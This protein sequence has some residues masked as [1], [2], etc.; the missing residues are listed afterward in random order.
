MFCHACF[1][2]IF[3]LSQTDDRILAWCSL[4]RII[5]FV[6][7][8]YTPEDIFMRNKSK[9]NKKT[10]Y[11]EEMRLIVPEQGIMKSAIFY[12]I[13]L[14]LGTASTFG[15]FY[16]SFDIPIEFFSVISLAIIFCIVFTAMFLMKRKNTWFVLVSLILLIL[17]IIVFKDTIYR[18]LLI[19]VKYILE[20][21]RSHGSAVGF[22][23][24][25]ES[26]IKGA[27][28]KFDATMFLICTIYIFTLLEAWL[29]EKRR[30][31]ILTAFVTLPFVLAPIF[32][33]ITPSFVAI[34]GMIIFYGMLVFLSPMLSGSK[35]FRKGMKGYHISSTAS[36]NPISFLIIPIFLVAAMITSII[37]PQSGFQRSKF[38]DAIRMSIVNGFDQS[39]FSRYMNAAFGGDMDKVNL[40][41]AGNISF[42]GSRILSVTMNEN[43]TNKPHT[44]YLKGYVG[45]V[46]AEDGW[47]DLSEEQSAKVMGI[48]GQNK[49]QKIFSDIRQS[50]YSENES[51]ENFNLTVQCVA[52]DPR[53]VYIPYG[54]ANI[55]PED[56]IS[57]INDSY[58]KAVD[59]T[60]GIIEYN[61]S[62]F[63]VTDDYE[64]I[65][66]NKRLTDYVLHI[67]NDQQMKVLILD[68]G[69]AI[70]GLGYFGV[71]DN[72]YI[73]YVAEDG[74][75]FGNLEKYNPEKYYG[76]IFYGTGVENQDKTFEDIMSHYGDAMGNYTYEYF[77]MLKR[78][79]DFA[80]ENYTQ[81]PESLKAS[82][83]KFIKENKIN[84]NST[85]ETVRDIKSLFQY[86]GKYTYTL[87]PGKTPED[88]D[89]AEYFLNQNKKGY[90]K[91]F[92]TA[93]VLLLRTAGVPARYA[94]GFKVDS[95]DFMMSNNYNVNL[96]DSDAH[97]WVEI[98]YSGTGWVPIEVT[99]A[100]Y[101]NNESSIIESSN[102]SSME[103]SKPET[104]ESSEVV[105]NESSITSSKT[106]SSI[107]FDNESNVGS[108]IPT[109]LIY[110][111]F[112][113]V[114]IGGIYGIL[115][116]NRT[117]RVKKRRKLF[118]D[119]NRNN[120]VL[121]V[122][123][124]IVQLLIYG[125]NNDDSISDF[126][127]ISKLAND[128]NLPKSHRE[129]CEYFCKE[130]YPTAQR[131]KF[132]T[133]KISDEELSDM[134]ETAEKIR[135]TI[136]GNMNPTKRFIAKYLDIL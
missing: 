130:I 54:L 52:G 78:Y 79:E 134:I 106:E 110:I 133:E 41:D 124:Y 5:Q 71:D 50:Y 104:P 3:L 31:F 63:S 117:I 97:A 118:A 25:W 89:F 68:D 102:E 108:D 24:G 46:Y 82:M 88:S 44:E 9:K 8:W 116:L 48:L 126:D 14:A 55:S 19:S 42:N 131:A 58:A 53:K 26:I 94:E 127:K 112:V 96:L 105:S 49:C 15:C 27:N 74:T 4:K 103:S 66:V 61:Y 20:A 107:S 40:K 70:G 95:K 23:S 121:A 37:F 43:R 36:A 87:S 73:Y 115:V 67:P 12:F 135:S 59:E 69:K 6:R 65:T 125:K 22:P 64:K 98:Y 10:I 33:P 128:E 120:A 76:N 136:I 114:C 123:G 21:F 7:C 85:V 72:G 81:V 28:K 113:P 38:L 122:Y 16:S 18:G 84:T 92:A 30:N 57:F 100:S 60:M 11:L 17:F 132:S 101:E 51:D 2:T 1:E 93:A 77:D 91:H 47:E 119:S 90:C 109:V 56:K 45:S 99:P 13:M 75:Y 35:A 129:L 32:V 29:I 80:N 62:A 39:D 111:A 86:S 34:I 83:E